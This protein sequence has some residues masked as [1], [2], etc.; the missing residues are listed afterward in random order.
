MLMDDGVM[1]MCY[2]TA[3]MPVVFGSTLTL[4]TFFF[5][6]FFQALLRCCI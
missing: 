6:L 4:P 1:V 2:A 5:S 3:A